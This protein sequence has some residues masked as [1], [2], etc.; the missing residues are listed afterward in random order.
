ME[1][2]ISKIKKTSF[3]VVISDLRLGDVTD[4]EGFELLPLICDKSPMAKVIIMTGYGLED[5]EAKVRE[6]GA[7][8]Y[9]EK[10][11]DL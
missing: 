8:F 11:I 10:P 4:W 3:D 2:A 6:K 7:D 9:F 1:A 5:V